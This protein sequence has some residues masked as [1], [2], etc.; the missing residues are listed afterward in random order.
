M[1]FEAQ[2]RSC[3]RGESWRALGSLV[4]QIKR[5]YGEAKGLCK[6]P[7]V[8]GAGRRD[9]GLGMGEPCSFHGTAMGPGQEHAGPTGVG[10]EL[11]L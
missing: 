8:H 1:L 4:S 7:Q 2:K 9:G 10:Q 6:T 3:W 5:C 11:C